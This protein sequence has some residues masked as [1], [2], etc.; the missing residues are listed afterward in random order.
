[1]AGLFGQG[2]R[3]PPPY[4]TIAGDQTK[5]ALEVLLRNGLLGSGNGPPMA[6]PPFN[7]NAP[8]VN[9]NTQLPFGVQSTPLNEM[10]MPS[11]KPGFFGKG[12][13]GRG[14]AGFLA[15]FAASAGGGTPMY[16]PTLIDQ[17]KRQEERQIKLQ[18][19]QQER[20]DKNADW[21]AEQQWK[22]DHPE[23]AKP[24][25]QERLIEQWSQLPDDDPRKPM[26]ERAIRGYQYTPNVMDA[27]QQNAIELSDH[28][29]GNS[30]R[31]KQTP[32]A[33][34]N[35]ARGITPTARAKYIAEA[36]SAISKGADPA[37]VQ[38]RL[39]QMGVQ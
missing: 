35:G 25:E 37:K 16:A 33:S 6:T 8:A 38:E 21:I 32:G 19:Y 2:Y 5:A 10:A 3:D 30:M 22:I 24:G 12:G 14:I 26:I 23:P 9:S 36:Q 17:R 27:R 39:R 34:A 18:D 13:T 15:D 28:R 1:M 7:P 11:P 20:G 29:L 31:L 4:S